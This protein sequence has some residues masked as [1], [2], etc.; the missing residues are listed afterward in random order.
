MLVEPCGIA[1]KIELGLIVKSWYPIKNAPK[2]TKYVINMKN[3]QPAIIRFHDI[4]YE[5]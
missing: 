1:K 4:N 2:I 3:V 5:A